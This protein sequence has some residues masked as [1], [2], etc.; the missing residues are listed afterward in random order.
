MRTPA[1]VPLVALALLLA[2]P[3]AAAR[4]DTLEL[5]DGRIVEGEVEVLPEGYRITSRLGES[6]L[7]KAE[8]KAHHPGATVDVLVRERLATLASD[9]AENRA[10]LARWLVE[11][12]RTED[13]HALAEQALALDAENATAHG[14]L[15]HER[16]G[17]RWMSHAEA[18]RGK[19]LELHD[20][21]WYTP[22]EWKNLADAPRKAAEEADRRAAGKARA[23]EVNRL[24]RLMSNPD[25][26]VRERAKKGIEAISAESGNKDLLRLAEQVAQYVKAA[27]DFAAASSS[28][29]GASV[30]S[31]LRIS[32]SKLRRPI[33]IFETSLSSNLGA[34]AVKIQL[35]E[36]E[37]VH[38]RTMV[39]IPAVVAK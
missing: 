12:G 15:G 4:A 38:V 6:V 33:K 36:L 34:G 13:G 3:A 24:V 30:L 29:A 27:D 25:P 37:V 5:T 39:G 1:R 18:M 32:M 35:P 10:R 31:E 26:A 23:D 28:G 17:G 22:E 14:V 11:V 19:G 21:R 20:G 8:V 2:G 9:D 16:H 7:P